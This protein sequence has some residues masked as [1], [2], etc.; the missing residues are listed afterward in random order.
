MSD[1][2]YYAHREQAERALAKAAKDPQI[3][4]IHETLAG[5]YADLAKRENLTAEFRTDRIA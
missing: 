4:T 2:A 3:R 5:K 1:A